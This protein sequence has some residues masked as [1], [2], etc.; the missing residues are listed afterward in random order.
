MKSASISLLFTPRE[1]SAGGAGGAASAADAEG[2]GAGAAAGG[3]DGDAPPGAFLINLID[4]PGHVDFCSEV[5]SA[6]RL[7]DGA[8]VLV[9]ACEGCADCGRKRASRALQRSRLARGSAALRTY[10]CVRAAVGA[11]CV[12]ALRR[13]AVPKR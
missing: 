7:S 12:C 6:A 10:A 2:A 4:S 9:D 13:S 11:A 8:L 3:G 1:Q 5:S